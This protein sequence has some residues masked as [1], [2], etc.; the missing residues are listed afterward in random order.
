ME[1][2][3]ELQHFYFAYKKNNLVLQKI[4]DG[5]GCGITAFLLCL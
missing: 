1:T 3:V 4:T 5:N 2:V